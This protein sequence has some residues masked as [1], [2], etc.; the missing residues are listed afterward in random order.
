MG[1]LAQ[2]LGLRIESLRFMTDEQKTREI[3]FL[4]D[5]CRRAA[6]SRLSELPKL[7]SGIAISYQLY[8]RE[9][10]V[11]YILQQYGA[12]LLV[13]TAFFGVHA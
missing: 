6:E 2:T 9:V 5:E 13:S 10:R 4:F 7:G 3:D 12:A 1:R 11:A 8:W